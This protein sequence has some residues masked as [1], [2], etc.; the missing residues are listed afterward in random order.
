MPT[1]F[2]VALQADVDHL[3]ILLEHWSLLFCSPL[4][5]LVQ[6]GP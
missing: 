6:V 2:N 4:V 1:P 3:V 5:T